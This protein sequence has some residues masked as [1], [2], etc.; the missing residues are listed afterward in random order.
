MKNMFQRIVSGT[1]SKDF[2]TFL[3]FLLLS[4]LIWHIEK[5]RQTYTVTTRL[6]IV[7]VDVPQGYIT[8][9]QLNKTITTTLESNGFSL[10]KMYL[11]DCRKI[12]VPLKPL[13]RLS[14]GGNMWAIYVPRRLAGQKTGLPES[15][16]I[17]DVLTDTVMI[18]LL[19]VYQ[20]KLPVLVRDNVA[21]A[22]QRTLSA[23]R[24]VTP[25]S[26][27]VTAT[28][29]ILDTMAAVPTQVQQPVTISDTTITELNLILPETAYANADKV[30]VEYDVEPYTEKRISVP[31]VGVNIPN[32]YTCK[33][34]PPSAK[35]S[36]NV[37]L[38]KFESANEKAFKVTANFKHVKPGGKDSRIRLNITTS[39]D[40]IQNITY[41]PS[42]AE[43]ILE[44]EK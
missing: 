30:S 42:F 7:C 40:F 14:T 25:D 23:P 12:K 17:T 21:L 5:L 44:K 13:R 39:P 31:I 6:E 15:I 34:F 26:I 8:D 27:L 32:G 3:L 43:F 11:T 33:I 1:K 29:N 28:S 9:P 16:K 20:R 37:G 10:L 24:K 2:R 4:I 36:F 22:P 38:S 18:P 19:T 41:S 35:L